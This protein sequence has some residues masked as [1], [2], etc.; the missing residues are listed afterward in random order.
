MLHVLQ[1]YV[2]AIQKRWSPI[3]LRTRRKLGNNEGIGGRCEMLVTGLLAGLSSSPASLYHALDLPS[4]RIILDVPFSN[5]IL[6][7][8]D[9][10]VT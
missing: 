10:I 3:N 4:Q 6:D 9:D 1:M 8:R 7:L 5:K 2:T